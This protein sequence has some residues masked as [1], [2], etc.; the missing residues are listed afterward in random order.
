MTFSRL[1]DTIRTDGRW[2]VYGWWPAER[3][4]RGPG[5]EE[6]EAHDQHWPDRSRPDRLA[7]QRGLLRESHGLH[8]HRDP[9]ATRIE[10]GRR[11]PNRRTTNDHPRHPALHPTHLK[12]VW[13]TR[14]AR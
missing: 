6:R 3:R 11:G 5:R 13:T 14:P 1:L 9:P 4:N 8:P 12:G 7:R 10:I 2:M